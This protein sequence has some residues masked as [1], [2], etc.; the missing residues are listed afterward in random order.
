MSILLIDSFDG[1]VTSELT[2]YWQ[3]Q[4]IVGNANIATNLPNAPARTGPGAMA[5]RPGGVA[6][7]MGAILVDVIVGFAFWT[8]TGPPDTPICAFAQVLGSQYQCQLNALLD[9]TLSIQQTTNGAI[10]ATTSPNGPLI[11][12]EVYHYIEWRTG[13]NEG[14]ALN[15]IWIDGVLVYSGYLATQG[16]PLPGAEWVYL[17]GA[18][19]GSINLFDDFY[20]V[21][22]DDGN[23]LTTAAGDSSVI[24]S[25]TS[26]EGDVDEWS[27]FPATNE[28][29]QNVHQ[30]PASD[31]TAYNQSPG[32]GNVD[33]Y[34]LSP[35]LATTDDILAILLVHQTRSTV[36][37]EWAQ[38]YISIDGT[39]YDDNADT[40]EPNT[41][42]SPWFFIYELNPL[43]N[44]P[45]TGPIFDASYWGI[46]QVAHPTAFFVR[47]YGVHN[48]HNGEI[49]GTLS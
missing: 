39:P 49:V 30:I 22:P 12:P 32:I 7:S 18:P 10:L 38:P 24:C 9:G 4:S 2:E 20:L 28:N 44:H 13:F 29:W 5:P 14:G 36:G 41:A 46:G 19:G 43:T 48:T 34:T 15:E 37:D 27:P 31:D 33:D 21:N 47:L 8:N 23:G 40:Y 26:A 16:Q 1:Y 42:Y 17:M 35:T 6:R 11:Q 25:I 3:D 45:W